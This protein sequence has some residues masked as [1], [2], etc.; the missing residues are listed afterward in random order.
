MYLCRSYAENGVYKMNNIKL[1][2]KIA[3]VGIDEFDA[4]K[5]NV[6]EDVS[7]PCAIMV[8]SASLHDTEFEPE[9]E[10]I[11]FRSRNARRRESSFSIPPERMQ[12]E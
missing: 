8:R 3:A 4:A 10:L 12:T 2:N 7:D 9:P 1:M 6:G 5:Y 11:I